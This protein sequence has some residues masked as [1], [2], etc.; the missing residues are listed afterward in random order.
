MN[1]QEL[2]AHIDRDHPEHIFPK[3]KDG[4][5]KW[6][7][8]ELESVHAELHAMARPTTTDQGAT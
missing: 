8:D 5:G 3:A 2:V 6:R 7:K 1:K 4:L